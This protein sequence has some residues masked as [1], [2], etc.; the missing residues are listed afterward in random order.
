MKLS[1]VK[2]SQKQ[3]NKLFSITMSVAIKTKISVAKPI[4]NVN[5]ETLL[6]R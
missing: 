3:T 4:T 2:E 5:L 1:E 6:L